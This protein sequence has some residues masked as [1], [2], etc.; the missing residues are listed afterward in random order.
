MTLLKSIVCFIIFAVPI[1]GIAQQVDFEE[2][3]QDLAF[4]ADVLVNARGAHN[5]ERAHDSFYKDFS[6]LLAED[7]SFDF[8]FDSLHW[9]SIQKSPDERFRF[10]SWQLQGQNKDYSYYGFYQD[11]DRLIELN[12]TVDFG[13]NFVYEDISPANWYGQLIYDI[14]PID[15]YYII[16]GFRQLDRFSKTKV[17]EIM[18]IDDGRLVFG[19]PIFNE[20]KSSYNENMSRVVIRYSADV[21]AN[22]TYNPVLNMLV[23][24]NLIERMGRIPGQGE[25]L[26]PDG[27][28]KAFKNEGDSWIYVD[29]LYAEIL[30][31]KPKTGNRKEQKDIFGKGKN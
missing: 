16:F 24:D 26:L 2:R 13:K 11:R 1:F 8:S 15:D 19:A 9:I 21:L 30:D 6:Q 31:E 12:S 18:R 20:G 4:Y 27:T 29:Q 3:Q 17:A 5:R 25:T 28:Y 23:F 10:I 22:I 7:G 14:V